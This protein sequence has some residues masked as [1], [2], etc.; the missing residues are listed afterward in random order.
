MHLLNS[1]FPL[2][3]FT[4]RFGS[5]D[6]CLDEIKKT[7]YPGGIHCFRCYKTTAHYK[8]TGRRAYSCAICRNQVYP[9]AGTIFEKTTTPLRLWFFAMYLMT[10]T[11]AEISA[12][13]LQ[14]EMGVTYKT[15]WR[16]YTAI[17]KLMAQNKGDLLT[18]K[19]ESTIRKWIFFNKIELKVV[20][21]QEGNEGEKET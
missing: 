7:R 19:P 10:Q 2:S 11:R 14:R 18:E 9:L 21:K 13:D 8:V 15:A 16:I 17:Y 1:L 20:Q 3:Q 4:T 12:K 6:A 5:E